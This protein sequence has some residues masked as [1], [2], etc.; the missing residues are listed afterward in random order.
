MHSACF[1]KFS[2]MYFLFRCNA[3]NYYLLICLNIHWTVRKGNMVSVFKR[4][5]Q[6]LANLDF[7]FN[8]FYC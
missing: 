8:L 7:G 6:S 2:Y 1:F 3:E 5:A 4:E